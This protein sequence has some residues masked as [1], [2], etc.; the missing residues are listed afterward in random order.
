M[1]LRINE[2]QIGEQRVAV[3][4]HALTFL[5]RLTF[6]ES[7]SEPRIGL[8][9][10]RTSTEFFEK[11]ELIVRLVNLYYVFGTGLPTARE[12]VYTNQL[13]GITS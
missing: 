8:S 5:D 1:K 13:L 9:V 3:Q 2:T 4:F 6:P 7:K 12:H 10:C 11:L